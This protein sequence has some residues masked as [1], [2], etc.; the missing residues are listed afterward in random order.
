MTELVSVGGVR[1]VS[2]AGADK[3]DS[4]PKARNRR[5]EKVCL[6]LVCGAPG[7]IRTPNLLIR[8]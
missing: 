5:S 1:E 2:R 6:R 7:E 8:S 3:A 4:G